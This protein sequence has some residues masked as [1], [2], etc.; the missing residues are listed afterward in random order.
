MSV[1]GT[2]SPRADVTPQ[3]VPDSSSSE[4]RLQAGNLESIPG[5]SRV[6]SQGDK[7]ETAS[8]I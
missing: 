3:V 1:T 2:I 4:C 6:W 5:C 7:E 8:E